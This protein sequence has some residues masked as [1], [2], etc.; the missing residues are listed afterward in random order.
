MSDASPT[1][2]KPR[3]RLLPRLRPPPAPHRLLLGPVFQKE[4]RVSGRR[5]HTYLMRSAVV[6]GLIFVVAMATNQVWD[7]PTWES[8]DFD[9]LQTLQNAAP[10]VVL[11]VGWVMLIGVLILSPSLTATAIGDER[12]R[13][14]L[15]AMLTTP[16]RPSEIVFGKLAAGLSQVVILVLLAL[17]VLL[18]VRVLGGVDGEVIAASAALTLSVA[19]LGAGIGLYASTLS[20]KATGSILLA[21]VLFAAVVALPP[22]A[23][24]S[25]NA[26]ASR[27]FPALSLD[28]L[29]GPLAPAWSEDLSLLPGPRAFGVSSPFIAMFTVSGAVGSVF[30]AAD[31]RPIWVGSSLGCIAGGLFACA[32]ASR[33]LARIMRTGGD[34]EPAPTRGKEDGRDARTI[35]DRPVLW[36]ELRQ[37]LLEKR[38]H[39]LA[40]ALGVLLIFGVAYVRGGRATPEFQMPVVFIG[41][42]LTVIMAAIFPA[43]AFAAERESRSLDVLLTTPIRPSEIVAAKMLGSLRRLWLVPLIIVA[44]FIV[45]GRYDSAGGVGFHLAVIPIWLAMIVGASILLAG[46]G[47]LISLLVKRPAFASVAN[48]AIASLIWLACPVSIVFTIQM[49][50]AFGD[51]DWIGDALVYQNPALGGI[52]LSDGC[53]ADAYASQPW[54]PE[55]NLPTGSYELG[56]VA[57]GFLISALVQAGVGIGLATLTTVL[58]PRVTGRAR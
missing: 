28:D 51:T 50:D 2:A 58:L 49:L 7:R 41:T 24:A 19:M 31:V 57:P 37:P 56:M 43:S 25:F 14:T 11:S 10:I 44:N 8:S 38:T 47:T 23:L 48:L 26:L 20:R 45:C 9:R 53:F 55:V 54:T 15:A 34:A 5:W 22:V 39:M 6:A 13:R 4:V 17:P 18:G 3:R 42:V 40:V 46:S 35:S 30:S 1:P 29:L 32:I 12:R 52:L 21:Y 27:H 33:R 36:R 16:L